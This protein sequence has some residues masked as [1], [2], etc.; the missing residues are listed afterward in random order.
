LGNVDLGSP[1]PVFK[2]ISYVHFLAMLNIF[3]YLDI[4][5]DIVTSLFKSYIVT[6]SLKTESKL[7]KTSRESERLK[8][9]NAARLRVRKLEKGEMENG[10]EF[11]NV[12]SQPEK[13]T[14]LRGSSEFPNLQIR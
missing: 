11:F 1:I 6:S 8:N 9:Y 4:D 5:I 13:E 12:P 3:R 2:S 10:T 14:T 7:I